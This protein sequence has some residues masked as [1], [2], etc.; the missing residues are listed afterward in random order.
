MKADKNIIC[1]SDKKSVS[2]MGIE[3]EA[4]SFTKQFIRPRPLG[5]RAILTIVV[6]I[7]IN[8]QNFLESFMTSPK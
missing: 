3:P 4:L 7:M 5:Q 2:V 6:K 1:N 8:N